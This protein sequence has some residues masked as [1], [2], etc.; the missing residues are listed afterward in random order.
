[1]KDLDKVLILDFGAQYAHL[2]ARRIRECRVYSDLIPYNTKAEDITKIKPKALILSGGPASV[3][4]KA[5]PLPDQAIYDLGIP[6]L[7]ICYGLQIIVHQLGGEVIRANK[8]E[9]GKAT[10]NIT[11]TSDIF[12]GFKPKAV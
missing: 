4:D 3:Y 1:M 5:A 2:I 12:K 6:I 10:L 7:G 11:D 8:R 9:Y